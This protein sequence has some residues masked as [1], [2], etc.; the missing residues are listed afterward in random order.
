MNDKELRLLTK[1]ID[2]YGKYTQNQSKVLCLLVENSIDDLVYMS[3][4]NISK[5][6]GV[7]RATVYSTL[8]VLQIDGMIKKAG[9]CKGMFKIVREK[10]NF[11]IKHY[12]QNYYN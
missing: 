7:T 9:N 8:N 6:T 11:M 2:F 10:I 4:V 3:V 5:K 12:N 1:S